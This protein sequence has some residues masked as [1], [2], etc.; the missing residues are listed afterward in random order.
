MVYEVNSFLP[1]PL[2]SNCPH[3][4]WFCL[5]VFSPDWEVLFDFDCTHWELLV[6]WEEGREDRMMHI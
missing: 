4:G 5:V 2:L 6:R 3:L 1:L